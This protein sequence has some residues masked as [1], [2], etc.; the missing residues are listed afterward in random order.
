MFCSIVGAATA[1]ITL[2]PEDNLPVTGTSF[3]AH[4]G[5]YVPPVAGGAGLLFDLSAA[6]PTSVATYQWQDPAMLP[7][8]AL[9]PAA[10]FALTNAGADTVFT[11]ATAS[12]MERLGDTQTISFLLLGEEFHFTTEF[13]DPVLELA[14]PVTYGHAPWTDLFSGTFTVDG[15]TATRSGSITGEA[16]AW[17]YLITPGGTDTVEVLRVKT[18]ISETIPLNLSGFLVTATHTRNTHAYYPMWG[19]YPLLSTV[20]D[21]LSSP[22]LTQNFAYTEWMDSS[23]VGIADHARAM[24]N[25]LI[26]PNPAFERAA[27]QVPGAMPLPAVATVFDPRGTRVSQYVVGERRVELNVQDWKVGVYQVVLTGSDGRRSTARMVVAR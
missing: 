25:L 8:G 22:F 15:T 19:K 27:V 3:P 23:A 10:Q 6:T 17:G 1:Q 12:G 20:S 21:T 13:S 16:D 26:S 7:N 2:A 9:F 11:Q 24:Y 5:A 14:L 18:R 4:R